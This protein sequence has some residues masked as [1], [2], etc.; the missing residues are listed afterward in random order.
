M[1]LNRNLAPLA[2][3]GAPL[4]GRT[5]LGLLGRVP[6][7]SKPRA[8]VVCRRG[9]AMVVYQP[10]GRSAAQGFDRIAALAFYRCRRMAPVLIGVLAMMAILSASAHAKSP[11]IE[12]ELHYDI[13]AQSLDAALDA[14]GATSGMQLL[15]ETAL[16]A[17]RRSTAV[18]GWY[19]AP[20]ALRLLLSGTGFD[21]EYT[22]ERAFTLVAAR[23]PPDGVPAAAAR[24]RLAEY[25]RFLGVVQ[26]GVMG[27]LCARAETRPGP[28]RLAMQFWIAGSGQVEKPALLSSTGEASRDAAIIDAIAR[29]T[30]T[31]G[32]PTGMPQPVTILL[33]AGG[34][35]GEGSC[36]APGSRPNRP[37]SGLPPRAAPAP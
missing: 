25:G 1:S 29:L 9:R 7:L 17:G 32:A 34:P 8:V 6:R 33:T 5:G 24:S 18:E 12:P 4:R 22:G 28:F 27:A 35:D 30:F 23:L 10:A 26:T 37:E 3:V 16:T 11:G 21:F 2:C 15:Y 13:P 20:A 31:E 19:T 14:Y 36:P